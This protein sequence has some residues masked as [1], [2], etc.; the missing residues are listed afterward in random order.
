MLSAEWGELLQEWEHENV[1]YGLKYIV[2][3]IT[4]Q[5][6][7]NENPARGLDPQS[8]WE[9]RVN[10][11]VYVSGELNWTDSFSEY[12]Y[13]DEKK[14]ITYTQG[15]PGFPKDTVFSKKEYSV[16]PPAVNDL[17]EFIKYRTILKPAIGLLPLVFYVFL[18][19]FIPILIAGTSVW[20]PP[21]QKRFLA[22]LVLVGVVL[23][24]ISLPLPWVNVYLGEQPFDS[25]SLTRYLLNLSAT[26]QGLGVV[27]S[28]ITLSMIIPLVMYPVAILFWVISQIFRKKRRLLLFLLFS[29]I[30]SIVSVASWTYAVE[31][32][33]AEPIWGPYTSYTIEMGIGS[34]LGTIAGILVLTS[35]RLSISKE[36]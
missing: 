17:R 2:F 6:T 20:L 21:Y 7:D 26:L 31:T 16:E 8:S 5:N 10:L 12:I 28:D 15:A 27:R 1:T 19:G 24:L 34:F 32:L 36:K 14:T 23:L 11:K 13:P 9:F 29:G 22:L 3:N 4:I 30:F 35:W 18:T 33:K 25:Y